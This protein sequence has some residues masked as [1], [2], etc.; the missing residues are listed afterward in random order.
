MI[1]AQPPERFFVRMRG[2][3]GE[4]RAPEPLLLDWLAA[5]ARQAE[6]R[7][8]GRS[9]FR[10]GPAPCGRRWPSGALR[11]ARPGLRPL[12]RPRRAVATGRRQRLR[13]RYGRLRDRGAAVGR[14]AR[15]PRPALPGWSTPLI[16]PAT[17]T[18]SPCSPCAV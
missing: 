13:D 14:A 12:V 18:S 1:T 17:A 5:P 10:Y 9:A 8:L 4:L 3:D 6:K 15:L 7:G 2:V 16:P 11:A